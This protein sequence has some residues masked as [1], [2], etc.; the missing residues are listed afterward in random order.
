VL[1]VFAG[2]ACSGKSTLAADVSRHRHIPHLSMDATRVRIMP[3]AA[4]TRDDR[5]VAYRAMHF[6]A[7]LLLRSG[8]SVILDAPYGH[9]EDREDLARI[10]PPEFKL[11]ECRVSPEAAVRR[12]RERG[13]DPVRLDLTEELVEHLVRDHPYTGRGLTLDT[14]V[15]SFEE[16]LRRI[17]AFLA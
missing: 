6:A 9:P 3:N 16:C 5:E 8:S 10:A 14:G 12:F 7:E 13:P 4:H 1:I 2:P 15:L 11:I 17:D